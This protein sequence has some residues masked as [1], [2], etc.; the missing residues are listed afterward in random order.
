MAENPELFV[1]YPDIPKRKW[2]PSSDLIHCLVL[3]AAELRW[4]V[5]KILDVFGEDKDELDKIIREVN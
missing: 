5:P 3:R 4:G 1:R 2:I